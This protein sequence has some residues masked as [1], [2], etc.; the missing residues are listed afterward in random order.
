MEETKYFQ[1]MKLNLLDTTTIEKNDSPHA[2]IEKITNI[3]VKLSRRP[4]CWSM[5]SSSAG[6][7]AAAEVVIID[8]YGVGASNPVAIDAQFKF[9]R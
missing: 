6:G 2:I 4:G 3:A 9:M 1:D 7:P 8:F 5:R